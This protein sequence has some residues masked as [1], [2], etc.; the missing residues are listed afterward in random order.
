MY[1]SIVCDPCGVMPAQGGLCRTG[2]PATDGRSDLSSQC[3]FMDER[4]MCL[5]SKI[6]SQALE[7]PDQ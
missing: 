6:K 7:F 1:F 5:H 3:P 2:V 4:I